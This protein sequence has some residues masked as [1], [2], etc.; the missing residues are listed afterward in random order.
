MRH[1]E[2]RWIEWNIAKCERHG[3]DPEA[4]EYVVRNATRPFPM[5]TD[6]GKIVVWGP[7]PGGRYLQVIYLVDPDDTLFVIHAM[8]LTER[9]KHQLRRRQP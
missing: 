2:F 8:P 5:T 4:A 7:Q 6:N 9:Q 3:V 1:Y